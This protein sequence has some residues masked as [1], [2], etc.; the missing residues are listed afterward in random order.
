VAGHE[1]PSYIYDVVIV[2][3]GPAGSTAAYYLGKYTDRR[4]LIVDKKEFPRYKCCAGGLF[5]VEDWPK[6]LENYAEVRSSLSSCPSHDFDF[7]CDRD[8][9]WRTKKQHLFDVVDRYE[10]DHRLLEAALKYDNIHFRQRIVKRIEPKNNDADVYRLTTHQGTV[11]AKYVIGADGFRGVVSRFL[12][13]GPA[14]KRDFGMC[15]QY[16]LVCEKQQP[17]TTSVFLNWDKELGFSWIFPN[18][19]GYTLGIGLIGKTARPWRVILDNFLAYCS[20]QKLI[21]EVHTRKRFS[22]APCPVRITPRYCN[23]N[24]LLCGDALGMVRQLTG[25]GIYYAMRTGKEAAY[26]LMRETPSV[27]LRKIYERALKPLKKEVVFMDPLPPVKISKVLLRGAIKVL[28]LP[29]PFEAHHKVRHGIVNKF[30]R[31]Y[32]LPKDSYYRKQRMEV[33]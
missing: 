3:A 15:L 8:L 26:A 27:S 22:A 10:F 13:N 24:I 9:Y 33:V 6:E 2:G 20:E 5:L 23:D 7:Y 4:V 18:P 28:S 11:K 31:M 14:Q 25:E 30:H 17:A 1:D 16:D 19:D 32:S 21:P 12:G 29:L